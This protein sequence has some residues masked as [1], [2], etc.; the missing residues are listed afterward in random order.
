M[1]VVVWIEESTWEACIDQA[2][3]LLPHDADVALSH[4]APTDAEELAG[5]GALFGRHGRLSPHL[6]G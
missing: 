3:E 4:V 5:G 1:R 2:G 6:R